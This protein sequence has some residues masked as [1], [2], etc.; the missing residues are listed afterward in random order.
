[1]S[2]IVVLKLSVILL[3]FMT[4]YFII[5]MCFD[6]KYINKNKD[7]IKITNKWWIKFTYFITVIFIL[8]TLII[9]E[10]LLYNRVFILPRLWDLEELCIWIYWLTFTAIIVCES[11]RWYKFKVYRNVYLILQAENKIEIN[12]LVYK[13]EDIEQDEQSVYIIDKKIRF[14]IKGKKNNRFDPY[15]ISMYVV[16]TLL[17]IL[18]TTLLFGG[19]FFKNHIWDFYNYDFISSKTSFN[20]GSISNIL[21]WI[22]ISIMIINIA[23]ISYVYIKRNKLYKYKIRLIEMALPII[24]NMIC[25][26]MLVSCFIAMIEY[27]KY[28]NND[29]YSIGFNLSNLITWL[30][31]DFTR[32]YGAIFICINIGYIYNYILLYNNNQVKEISW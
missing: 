4:S 29:N 6:L 8:L 3:A 26:V 5:D 17:I 28:N 32:G 24:I 19:I 23:L 20:P 16:N 12:Q 11:L 27:I 21:L 9:F 13:S 18:L 2:F 15:M 25:I 30:D 1:M 10:I 14:L 7:K 31:K 22:L